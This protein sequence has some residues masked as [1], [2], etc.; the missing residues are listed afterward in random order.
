VRLQ[1]DEVHLL[2][3][4]VDLQN[5]EASL[6]GPF[7]SLQRH[8]ANLIGRFI[9]L[10]NDEANLLGTLCRFTNHEKD[11]QNKLSALMKLIFLFAGGL[12]NLGRFGYGIYATG[13]NRSSLPTPSTKREHR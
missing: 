3:R 9:G 10:Q 11:L 8:E 4:F 13:T 6:R 7:V 5:H 1:S 12:G 2:G